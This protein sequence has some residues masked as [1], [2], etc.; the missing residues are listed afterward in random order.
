RP[1]T[2]RSRKSGRPAPPAPP[3]RTE[4]TSDEDAAP[5]PRSKLSGYRRSKEKGI[6]MVTVKLPVG[7]LRI[8]D[9]ERA[10]VGSSRSVF[11]S[12]LL[13][14]KRGELPLDRPKQAPRD[15]E[16]ADDELRNAKQWTWYMKPEIRPLLDA[17]MLQMGLQNVGSWIVMILN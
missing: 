14:R 15:F 9:T 16:I 13:R 12:Q 8:L 5:I 10:L 3:P 1:R 17:D 11:L 4:D 7:Y 2:D 6:Q